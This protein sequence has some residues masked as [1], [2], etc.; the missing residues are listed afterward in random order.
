MFGPAKCSPKIM[1]AR[2]KITFDMDVASDGECKTNVSFELVDH[3]EIPCPEKVKELVI[4]EIKMLCGVMGAASKELFSEN[5][6]VS[7]SGAE[8]PNA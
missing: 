8:N 7:E 3:P 5:V 4:G 6:R 2:I 1:N